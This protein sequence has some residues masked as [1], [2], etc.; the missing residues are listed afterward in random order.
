MKRMAGQQGLGGV[1]SVG[2]SKAK[3]YMETDKRTILSYLVKPFSD[4][5]ERAFRER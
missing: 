5:F 3:V 1:F 2:K 4:N